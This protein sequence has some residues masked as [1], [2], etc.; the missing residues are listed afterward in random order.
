[1]CESS[2]KTCFP[3]APTSA[4]S[5]NSSIW[6]WAGSSIAFARPAKGFSPTGRRGSHW[7]CDQYAIFL[8]LPRQQ[9]LPRKPGHPIADKAYALNK[10][11][12]LDTFYEVD[13]PTC[14][15]S[16]T[17]SAVLARA[18]YSGLFHLLI[19]TARCGANL[20]NDYPRSARHR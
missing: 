17:P 8:Y 13:C 18:S 3:T 12:A 6:R 11:H 4:I 20:D 1:M 5:K 14:S 7:H 15:R 2:S 16:S 9:R 10:V 19:T